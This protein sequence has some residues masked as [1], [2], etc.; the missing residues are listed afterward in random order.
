MRVLC[1]MSIIAITG[2][3]RINK[4]KCIIIIIID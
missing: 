4:A 1:V 2:Y 3:R